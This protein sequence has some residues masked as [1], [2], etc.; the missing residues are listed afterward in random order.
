M[1]DADSI[2]SLSVGSLEAVD[3]IEDSNM[4]DESLP[5]RDVE[6]SSTMSWRNQKQ[7]ETDHDTKSQSEV[8]DSNK[9]D[10]S[11][12]QFDRH[13]MNC[14]REDFGIGRAKRVQTF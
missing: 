14:H 12:G 2:S 10:Q 13:N 9:T 5:T 8:L 6:K 4:T 3:K 1:H 7:E 11:H